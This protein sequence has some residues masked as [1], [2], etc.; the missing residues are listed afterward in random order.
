M[1]VFTNHVVHLLGVTYDGEWIRQFSV[2]QYTH[3]V[4]VTVEQTDLA[5]LWA[6][7]GGASVH[8]ITA[9][10]KYP[11]RVSAAYRE[12]DGK[13]TR[14]VGRIQP[15]RVH[16]QGEETGDSLLPTFV[17]KIA[18]SDDNHHHVVDWLIS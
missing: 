6:G 4:N 17:P 12:V 11:H 5:S 18:H 2:L 8:N 13:I 3:I 1:S 9:T 14:R 16:H 10:Q 15:G 7:R